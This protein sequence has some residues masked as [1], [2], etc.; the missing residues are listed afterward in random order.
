[1]PTLRIV[2]FVML[3]TIASGPAGPQSRPAR[4]GAVEVKFRKVSAEQFFA[5]EADGFPPAQNLA[6]GG[7]VKA[8]STHAEMEDPLTVLGGVR[9][10]DVWA[11][12]DDHGILELAWP[13]PVEA[14]YILLFNRPEDFGDHWQAATLHVNGKR[15]ATIDLFR[16]G[17]VLIVDL[18]EIVPVRNVALN[19]KGV[20][21]PGLVGLEL[22]KR[23]T[24]T[25][26]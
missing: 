19:I 10:R 9:R 15:V 14:R 23:A 21:R 22:H 17:Q 24:T 11:F 5:Q 26:R 13:K 25:N 1:M 18:G 2:V 20:A 12:N 16:T 6:R 7:L 8:S 3:C 4:G